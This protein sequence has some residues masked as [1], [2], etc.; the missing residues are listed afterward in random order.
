[1]ENAVQGYRTTIDRKEM[2]SRRDAGATEFSGELF[3]DDGVSAG[4]YASIIT[5]NQ[6]LAQISGIAVY[7]AFFDF[8]LPFR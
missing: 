3:F 7:P 5:E 2:P 6:Q 8:V 1:L 4:F